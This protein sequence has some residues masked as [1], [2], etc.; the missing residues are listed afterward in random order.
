MRLAAL[1]VL[2]LA[3]GPAAGASLQPRIVN[4]VTTTAFP[5]VGMLLA[6]SAP[7]S[8]RMECT[9]TMIG[10]RTF[11]T[12]AHCVCDGDGTDC[13]PGG[14]LAPDP[15][16]LFVFLQHA[17]TFAVESVTVRADYAFPVADVAVLR[18]AA[19]VSG[20]RPS[21]LN[22]TATPASGTPG[23]VVGFGRQGGAFH[24]YG[25][26]RTGAVALSPCTTVPAGTSVCWQFA[27][28]IGAP[29][30]DSNTCNGDSGGPLFVDLGLGP[31]VAG[32]TSGGESTDCLAPDDSFDA[33]VF[34][35]AGWIGSVAGSDLAPASCGDVA[36][37]GDAMV[38]VLA[39]Q[40]TLDAVSPTAAFTV[41]APGDLE[42]LRVVLNGDDAAD[43]D[44]YVRRGAPASETA[45]DCKDDG[46]NQYAACRLAAPAAGTWHVLVRRF[47]GSGAFQLTA[48][49]FRDDGSCGPVPIGGA[50][51]DGNACTGGDV[52]TVG[53]CVGT[54]LAAGTSCDDG[55]ACTHD[56]AC[57]AGTCVA[58]PAPRAGCRTPSG[59]GS[60][61]S[62]RDGQPDQRDS[63][64][65]RWGR[66]SAT[67]AELGTPGAGDGYALCLYETVG[68]T[69]RLA[70]GQPLAG[71]T[72]WTPR[73][74]GWRYTDRTGVAG[75][76]TGVV[77][78]AGAGNGA[79]IVVKAKGTPLALPV[80]P[81]AVDPDVTVQLVGPAACFEARY[82]G[83]RVNDATRFRARLD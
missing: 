34:A 73:S 70:L 77:L 52:C 37:V 12:A 9:G 45:F 19:P 4:G 17:G 22:Q 58:T 25:I 26:K 71:G 5:S 48:S 10:C 49:R 35:Y 47:S 53:G 60:T 31:V 81:L 83:A 56:D 64:Q 7:G 2:L 72:G 41:E 46:S 82:P 43:F 24:D 62:V 59:G 68:G 51:D 38:D 54:P 16:R 13:Q 78:K 50:C 11:L 75:G 32:V 55:N 39:F 44:L 74:S 42:E 27:D 79:R 36:Q 30:T 80:L 20:I 23:T 18:L 3:A 14:S 40:G 28:P 8:A 33:D 21:R 65:W 67:L 29:G 69:S 6:G 66:G 63:L 1:A 57:V 76:I 61:L 15:G